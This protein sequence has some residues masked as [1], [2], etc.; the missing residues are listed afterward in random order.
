MTNKYYHG[1]NKVPTSTL[2]L[3]ICHYI[4][5]LYRNFSHMKRELKTYHLLL[6]QQ[7]INTILVYDHVEPNIAYCMSLLILYPST[8]WDNIR[9][10]LIQCICQWIC[11]LTLRALKRTARLQFRCIIFFY[12]LVNTALR[13]NK[14]NNNESSDRV[15]GVSMTWVPHTLSKWWRCSY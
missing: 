14:Q 5:R 8:E 4:F 2:S 10:I 7:W 3:T 6:L 1:N 13:T 15:D 12:F 9:C 11:I